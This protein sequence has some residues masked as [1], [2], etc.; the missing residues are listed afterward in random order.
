MK[1][2]ALM[3]TPALLLLLPVSAYAAQIF[4][5]LKENGRPVPAGVK[6][7]VFC[8]GK[9]YASGQTDGYGAYSINTA[10]GK[11]TFQV[12]YKGDAP[13]VDVYSYDNA[14]RY[15]FDLVSQNGKYILW[16]K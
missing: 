4:G 9:S 1:K 5:S 7:E 3:I 11:C 16:R 10:R 13:Y 8:G 2:V 12:Y 15:D 6:F 14:V